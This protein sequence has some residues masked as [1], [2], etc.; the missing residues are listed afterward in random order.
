[1]NLKDSNDLCDIRRARKTKSEWFTLAQKH[2]SGFIQ[3]RLDYMFISNTLQKS[4]TMGEIL[5]PIS[6][7]HSLVLFSLRNLIVH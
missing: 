1:M 2:S 4:V 3:P 7:D 5:T 6:A